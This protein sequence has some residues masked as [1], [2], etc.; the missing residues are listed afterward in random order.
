MKKVMF[1]QALKALN[2]TKDVP[3]DVLIVTKSVVYVECGI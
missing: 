1:L 2:A 3:D